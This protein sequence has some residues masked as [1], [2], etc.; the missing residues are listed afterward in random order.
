MLQ[1]ITTS[2]NPY[3]DSFICWQFEKLRKKEKVSFGKRYSVFSPW[4]RSNTH[5]RM[6]IGGR[7]SFLRQELLC[8]LSPCY[9]C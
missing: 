3:Y 9:S 1:F 7:E 4:Y 6:I 8:V 2:V 5:I